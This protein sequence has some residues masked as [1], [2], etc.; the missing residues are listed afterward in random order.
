MREAKR[1][2]VLAIREQERERQR[3]LQDNDGDCVDNLVAR[4]KEGPGLRGAKRA[5]RVRNQTD[6]EQTSGRESPADMS[7]DQDP[8]ARALDLLKEL[9][10][11]GEVMV[12]L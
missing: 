6:S 8:G 10:G 5:R 2:E 1:A 3:A 4:L 11:D 7:S 9:K 12:L